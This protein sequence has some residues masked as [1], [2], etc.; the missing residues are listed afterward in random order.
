MAFIAVLIFCYKH[1][2][3]RGVG[4]GNSWM[5]N[6]KDNINDLVFLFDWIEITN[7]TQSSKV[8][9]SNGVIVSPLLKAA[10]FCPRSC[11]NIELKHLE[12]KAR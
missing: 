12:T 11:L 10:N 4:I 6:K 7:A 1:G 9:F 5:V 3:H 8:D 2:V